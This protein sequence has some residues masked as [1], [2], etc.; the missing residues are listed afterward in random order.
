MDLARL[1]T[2]LEELLGRPVDV[3]T[4]NGLRESVRTAAPSRGHK[5]LTREV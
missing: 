3:A 2:R 5:C 1:E 4:E